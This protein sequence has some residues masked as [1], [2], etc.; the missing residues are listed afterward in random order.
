M[1]MKLELIAAGVLAAVT[2]SGAWPYD[3]VDAVD[4]DPLGRIVADWRCA[5]PAKPHR[6]LLFS[7]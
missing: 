3:Q 2:A 5:K 4:L 6:V 1:N 7:E